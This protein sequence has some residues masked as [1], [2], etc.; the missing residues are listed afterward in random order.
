MRSLIV[1]DYVEKAAEQHCG[2]KLWL[3][4]PQRPKPL[5]LV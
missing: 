1:K 5:L 4:F 2:E 3:L